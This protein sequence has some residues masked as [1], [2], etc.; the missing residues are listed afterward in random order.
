MIKVSPSMLSA[1]YG[2]L[3]RDIKQLAVDGA[4]YVHID[5]MDGHFVPNMSF[6]YSIV[7]AI[8]KFSDMVLD[9]HLMIERPIRYVEE[10]CKAGS[11]ILT[12]H[13]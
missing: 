2:N 4:D 7:S 5:I 10:F 9:V 6:G 8:R 13:V 11:D 1:D 12:I 3:E